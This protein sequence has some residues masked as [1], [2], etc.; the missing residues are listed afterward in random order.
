VIKKAGR[1]DCSVGSNGEHG[2]TFDAVKLALYGQ[3]LG[4]PGEISAA[5]V[6]QAPHTVT[7][8]GLKH[9][10]AALLARRRGRI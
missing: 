3:T 9:P 2:D 5:A 7:R 10:L 4:K 1:F 6:G 8:A